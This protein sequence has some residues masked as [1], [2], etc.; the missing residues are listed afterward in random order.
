M[1]YTLFL[2]WS[3]PSTEQDGARLQAH[4]CIAIVIFCDELYFLHQGVQLRLSELNK[5]WKVQK[6]MGDADLE[7]DFLCFSDATFVAHCKDG[8]T[9]FS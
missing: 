9:T 4:L 5:E 6:G 1:I 2:K 7:V 8:E 3:C